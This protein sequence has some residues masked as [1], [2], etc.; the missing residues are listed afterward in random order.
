MKKKRNE[1]PRSFAF[2]LWSQ[3]EPSAA[4][5]RPDF[6][7]PTYNSHGNNVARAVLDVAHARHRPCCRGDRRA[8]D[9]PSRDLRWVSSAACPPSRRR[10]L[11]GRRRQRSVPMSVFRVLVA[12]R[13]SNLHSSS[14]MPSMNLLPASSQLSVPI[15]R[16]RCSKQFRN[17]VK[18]RGDLVGR[19]LLGRTSQVYGS[20]R[21]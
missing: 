17:S 18:E 20:K 12:D 13:H 2:S 6:R 4:A 15:W 14:G 16:R 21:R 7:R 11:A 8:A 9:G 10:Y 1:R 19:A 5:T 3:V